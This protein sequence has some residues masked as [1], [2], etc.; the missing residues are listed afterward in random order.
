MLFGT[1][2]TRYKSER[3]IE[4]AICRT[5]LAP[6]NQR[7]QPVIACNPAARSVD[8]SVFCYET[9]IRS[10]EANFVYR[11]PFRIRMLSGFRFFEVDEVYDVVDNVNSA[12][13]TTVGFF[14]RAENTMAGGQIGA[15]GTLIS[16]N[17][18][19]VFGSCKWALLS[20]DAFGTARALNSSGAPIEEVAKDSI[21]SQFLD[22]QL[23]GSLCLSK[24]FSVY[25]GYQGLVASDLAM[26]FEQNRNATI[27]TST[28]PIYASDSQ[29]HG[30][31]LNLV[32]IW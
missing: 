18:G 3:N 7:C 1:K 31:R 22:Y 19:R 6:P 17:N 29:W 11:A 8:F 28:N 25:A 24:R 14:S 30:F 27:F 32:G 12:N 4:T 23:G 10:F 9:Q 15:E 13:G 20:N 16:N 2:E 21:A 26:V 5:A